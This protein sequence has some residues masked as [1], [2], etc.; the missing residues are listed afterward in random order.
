MRIVG[1]IVKID[2]RVEV[3]DIGAKV[4]VEAGKD[5]ADAIAIVRERH[6]GVG[7]HARA[8]D[9]VPTRS[10]GGVAPVKKEVEGFVAKGEDIAPKITA[11]VEAIFVRK[12]EIDLCIEVVEVV[13]GYG[14]EFGVVGIGAVDA[15]GDQVSVGAT[16]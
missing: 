6:G 9:V 12:C 15:A 7:K 4:E 8:I 1:L 10:A 5:I 3:F 16:P 13:V 11:E 2:F 14:V